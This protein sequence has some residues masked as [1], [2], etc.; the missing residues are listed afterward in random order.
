MLFTSINAIIYLINDIGG[1]VAHRTAVLID[2]ACIPWVRYVCKG[3]FGRDLGVRWSGL[4][5]PVWTCLSTTVGVLPAWWWH[6][7]KCAFS[8]A[9]DRIDK[10]PRH[11]ADQSE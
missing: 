5:R 2:G 10:M 11:L 3:H 4:T 1:D 8:W 6:G 9:N 7:M